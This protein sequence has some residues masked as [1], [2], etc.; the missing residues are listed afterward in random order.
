MTECFKKNSVPKQF[1]NFWSWQWI[2][3]AL[4][5]TLLRNHCLFFL[6]CAAIEIWSEVILT[7]HSLLFHFPSIKLSHSLS[8]VSV[9]KQVQ[10]FTSTVREYCLQMGRIEL[11]LVPW[12]SSLF[13][14]TQKRSLS[15]KTTYIFPETKG[16]EP[17]RYDI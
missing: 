12:K 9:D 2:F 3:Y 8:P 10:R 14:K 15:V 16:R 13:R 7:L 6:L 11:P 1:R 17:S 4:S 5:S